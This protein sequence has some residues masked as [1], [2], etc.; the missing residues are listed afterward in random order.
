MR[1]W[2]FEVFKLLDVDTV[3]MFDSW[4][5]PISFGS[6]YFYLKHFRFYWSIVGVLSAFK[7][8]SDKKV[9]VTL[10]VLYLIRSKCN[11]LDQQ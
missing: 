1:L 5:R 4:K 10:V 6:A 3:I 2:N 9:S 11:I 8:L 7:C